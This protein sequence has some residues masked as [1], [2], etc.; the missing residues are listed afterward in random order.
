MDSNHSF[1][2]GDYSCIY[3]EGEALMAEADGYNFVEETPQLAQTFSDTRR[4]LPGEDH[5]FTIG[6]TKDRLME[7]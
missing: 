2:Q 5:R 6:R 3:A 1:A 7:R 4:L